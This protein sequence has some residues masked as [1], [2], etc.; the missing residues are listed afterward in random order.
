[1]LTKYS[2]KKL[3]AHFILKIGVDKFW[4]LVKKVITSEKT[5]KIQCS[6]YGEVLLL[7][8]KNAVKNGIHRLQYQLERIFMDIVYYALQHLRY[9]KK[10][11]AMLE[12]FG[13]AR[14]KQI[15]AMIYRTFEPNLWRCLKAANET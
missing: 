9:N 14:S 7:A 1:M 11:M 12:F 3:A 4:I 5:T 6:N 8:W 10:F 15:D 2:G 13:K